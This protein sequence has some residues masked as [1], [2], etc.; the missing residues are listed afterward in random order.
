MSQTPSPS[1][2]T[3]SHRFL[4]PS[5]RQATWILPRT[6]ERVKRSVTLSVPPPDVDLSREGSD[7]ERSPLLGRREESIHPSRKKLRQVV[8]AGRQ[9]SKQAWAF[10][11][12]KTGQGILKCSLAYLLGCMATFVAPIAGFLGQ[13]DGKHIVA[14]ITVYFNP[15][16][17]QGSM[18]EAIVLAL[19][20]FAYATFIS[21]ASMGI[22]VGFNEMGL[23]ALGHAIV[24]VIFC[25]GGLGFVGWL[26][27]RLEQP[28]VNVACSLA[29]LA[30]ITVLTKEGSVQSSRFSDDKIQQVM[31]MVIMGILA[32]TFVSLT[33]KPISA[34][35]ELREAMIR[36]T[37]S[38]GDMLAMITKSFLHGSDTQ[39]KQSS[40]KEASD[41]FQA[42]IK[43]LTKHLKE[44]KNEHYVYG[45]EDEYHIEVRLTHCMQRLA[46]SIGGL[47]SAA[48]TQFDLLAQPTAGS[49]TPTLPTLASGSNSSPSIISANK[50]MTSQEHFA[51]LT[52]IDEAP[53]DENS[54]ESG[55]SR[56]RDTT[57]DR[58]TLPTVNSPADIFARFIMHL[59]PSMKSLAY[60][61]TQIL[62]ELPF[63][64]APDFNIAINDQ[65]RSSLRDAIELYTK[66]RE[67]ALEILYQ[68]KELNQERPFEVA[69]DFEEVTASCGHFSFSLHEFAEETMAYLNI[70]DDLRV[71]VDQSP[72]HRSWKWLLIWRHFQ[73]KPNDEPHTG[74]EESGLI[75]PN[76]ETHLSYS[77]ADVYKRQYSSSLFLEKADTKQALRYRVSSCLQF[78][79]RDDIKF[80]VKV[81]L[82]AAI[83][84][85]TLWPYP[86]ARAYFP[87]RFYL[88]FHL[89]DLSTVIGGGSGAYLK[90]LLHVTCLLADDN[91]GSAVIYAGASN[92]TGFARFFGTCIGAICAIIAWLVSR[93]NAFGL[94]ALGW[95]MS[96]WCFYIIVARGKGPMGRFILLTYN[97]S[98]LYAYSLSVADDDDDDDEGGTEPQITEITLHR[99]VAVMAGCLWGLLITRVIWPI[100]ARRKLKDGLSLLWLRMGL[101]WKRDPLSILIEGESSSSYMDIR[102]EFELQRFVSRLDSLRNS[103]SSEFELKG[104]FSNSSYERILKSTSRMLDSFHA[105]NVVITKDR[106]ASEG[107]LEILKFT[108]DERAHL[109]ARISHLYQVLASSMKL[110]YPINDALP[111]TENARDRLLARVFEYRKTSRNDKGASDK[112]FALL[113]AYTLVT[114]QLSREIVEV[115]TDIEK[116]FG[117]LN[118]DMLKLQ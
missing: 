108:A 103:A 90:T 105:M 22:S 23:Q 47:R 79:R 76:E 82:G 39:M 62:D 77:P 78:F 88:L 26:K 8:N 35:K 74:L 21:F 48:M 92:T 28:L 33:I 98:A 87:R 37:D 14:T 61:L 67:E 110:E 6:G 112:D 30:I 86:I 41:K 45:T 1:D 2:P 9:R 117:V 65:F 40:Y 44:A 111:S 49:S 7:G 85:R 54:S 43:S 118:E 109:C 4:R 25:G 101:V 32:T 116:L 46:Q 106:R 31:K 68:E 102:E 95:L 115:S 42:V 18:L 27:Q 59:G 55:R 56:S 57:E 52:A 80:A 38:L 70:L 73:S 17:S 114:G 97:L 3:P 89:R 16:R 24:V 36:A 100:S 66:A 99:V 15:A 10:A 60:T 96:L 53:E 104:P 5:L 19:L 34:R 58:S 11:T 72:R 50:F 29:S 69:A 64:P 83:Y 20:A 51:V 94:A 84:V 91:Q 107:E 13:Q 71:E 63:A 81:G 75:D 113:Y 12:S 93:G